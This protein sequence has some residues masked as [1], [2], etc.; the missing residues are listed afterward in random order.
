MVEGRV[1]PSY[2]KVQ[3]VQERQSPDQAYSLL[4]TSKSWFFVHSIPLKYENPM[5]QDPMRGGVGRSGL[6]LY[7]GIV[8]FTALPKQCKRAFPPIRSTSPPAFRLLVDF[9]LPRTATELVPLAHTRFDQPIFS[10]AF[11]QQAPE[12]GEMHPIASCQK[13]RVMVVLKLYDRVV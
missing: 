12:T 9:T 1:L 6:S 7:A 10:N 2:G 5:R 13:Q 11:F 3:T 8:A 4:G